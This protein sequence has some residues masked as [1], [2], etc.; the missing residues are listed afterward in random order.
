MLRLPQPMPER[1]HS[2]RRLDSG[3]GGILAVYE[4]AE[5]K[6]CLRLVY[7]PRHRQFPPTGRFHRLY[8]FYSR[9]DL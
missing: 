8:R 2:Q 7:S 1:G 6:V 5:K 3:M 4:R 9:K